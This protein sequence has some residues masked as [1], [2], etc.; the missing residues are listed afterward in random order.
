[1]SNLHNM[2]IFMINHLLLVNALLLFAVMTLGWYV[3][4]RRQRLDTVDMFWGIGFVVVAWAVFAQQPSF[5]SLV[6]L[7]LVTAWGWRLAAHIYE[8][9][10]VKKDDPRYLELQS[11]WRGNVWRRAYVSIFLLQGALV[12]VVSLPVVMAA[13]DK[14][15]GFGW[16][17]TVGLLLWMIGFV[18]EYTA[19][20]QLATFVR[21]KHKTSVLQTGL[22]RYSRHPNYFGELL[23]WWAIALIALQASWGWIGLLGPLMLT[24]LILFVSGLPPIERRRKDDPE[25]QKYKQRTSPLIPLPP[26]KQ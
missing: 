18:T 25:Y 4:Y 9:T 14:I 13:N 15:D 17:T 22:W 5:R 16:L 6:I 7:V 26:Q 1:M 23:Q 20:S 12:W 3:A 24:Y 19:D 10:K 21:K 8:R 11:K 2:D